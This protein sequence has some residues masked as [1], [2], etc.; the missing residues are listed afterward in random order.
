[1]NLFVITAVIYG[2][3]GMAVAVYFLDKKSVPVFLWVIVFIL[4][5]SQPLLIGLL[6][7]LGLF[8]TWLDF[9]KLKVKPAVDG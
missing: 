7:G 9:R 1:L 3:Q 5:F 2:L 6:L 4:I 8:D